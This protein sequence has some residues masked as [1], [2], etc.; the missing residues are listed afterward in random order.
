MII[1]INFDSSS[2]VQKLPPSLA[3]ISHD[4]VVLIELQGELELEN[5][6][7]RNGRLIGT[8]KID[9]DLVRRACSA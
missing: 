2:S 5:P 4:E 9:D 8:L 6:S 3:K 1:P 7:Q